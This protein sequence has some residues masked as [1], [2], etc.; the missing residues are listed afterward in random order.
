VLP[1]R[2]CCKNFKNTPGS[3][4]VFWTRLLV[5]PE[6]KIWMHTLWNFVSFFD[7]KGLCW[8]LYDPRISWNGIAWV[9]WAVNNDHDTTNTP[10]SYLKTNF[11]WRKCKKGGEEEWRKMLK[12]QAFLYPKTSPRSFESQ[13]KR[14]FHSKRSK[15]NALKLH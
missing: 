11:F 9:V 14:V 4:Y 12:I 8:P 6:N 3:D 10:K 13:G 1:S 2:A 15:K 7:V 5:F